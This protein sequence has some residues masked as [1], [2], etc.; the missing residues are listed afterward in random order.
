VSTTQTLVQELSN[1]PFFK[2]LQPDA[3]ELIAGCTFNAVFESDQFIFQA[4][5]EANTFYVIR[6]GKVVVQAGG[7]DR[8]MVILQ[9]LGPGDVLGWSWLFP[10]YR[11]F[12]DVR[13]LELTHTIVFD[14]TCIRAMS[15]QHEEFGYELMK[16]IASVVGERLHA[17][18]QQILFL[19]GR[20]ARV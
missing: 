4:G 3:L 8:G 16:R 10:P 15:E 12:F 13:T 6:S 11:W 14:A 17:T 2:G 18:R 7:A 20:H 5:D 1:Y 9:T 19:H